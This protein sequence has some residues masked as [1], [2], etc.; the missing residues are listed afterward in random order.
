MVL[1][2]LLGCWDPMPAAP[3][4]YFTS[5]SSR[6]KTAD[7]ATIAL[8][9][10]PAPG[11]PVLL[12]HGI[13]SNHHYFDL[14]GSHNLASWLAR[15]GHDV[16]MLDLRGHGDAVYGDHGRQIAGWTIDDYGLYD[17]DAAIQQIRSVTGAERVDYVGHSMGGMVGAIYAV[18]HGVDRLGAMVVL[19]SPASFSRSD[20]LAGVV[21]LGMAVGGASLLW[22]ESP[23]FGAI[24]ADLKGAVPLH[25]QEKLYNPANY[26]PA[27]IDAMLRTIASPLAR[28]EM[29]HFGRML[30][31]EA[32]ESWDRAIDYRTAL[33]SI[34]LPVLAIGSSHDEVVPAASVRAFA[35]AVGGKHAFFLASDGGVEHG[36]GH[37]DYALAENAPTEIFPMIDRWLGER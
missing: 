26:E 37:L 19:G 11:P 25:L 24:A 6:L 18:R 10:H 35:D 34:D 22:V 31:D 1:M 27:T 8:H 17:V 30:K 5:T 2:L 23:A 12:V 28:K 21:E 3:D 13:S 29:Q 7:G 20:P 16:W 14:D 32:F 15:R 36:Y 4:S 33:G 9:H